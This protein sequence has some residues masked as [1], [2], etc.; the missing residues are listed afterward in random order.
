MILITLMFRFELWFLIPRVD[1]RYV[2]FF[3]IHKPIFFFANQK[4]N[5]FFKL[6]FSSSP[7][8]LEYYNG[9]FFIYARS[10]FSSIP[11][12][13]TFLVNDKATLEK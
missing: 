7:L 6:S 3:R 13:Y 1:K 9:T 11:F 2:Q 5:M 8:V 12:C 10:S 4:K